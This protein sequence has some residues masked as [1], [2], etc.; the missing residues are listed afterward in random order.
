M[1]KSRIR[2]HFQAWKAG[3]HLVLFWDRNREFPC[4]E[5][6]QLTP[7]LLNSDVAIHPECYR[8]WQIGRY[9]RQRQD[10]A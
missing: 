6:G 9:D 2:L 8:R 3:V 10:L 7:F 1:R 5:C 4:I